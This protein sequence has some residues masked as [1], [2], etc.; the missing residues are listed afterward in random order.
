MFD[1]DAIVGQLE[2]ADFLLILM[3][4]RVAAHAVSLNNDTN[5]NEI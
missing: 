3:R 1:N 4:S 2:Q 5:T